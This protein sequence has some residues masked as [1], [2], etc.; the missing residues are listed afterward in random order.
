MR[1]GDLGLWSECGGRR[2]A[3]LW[4]ENTLNER[5]S[6]WLSI[7]TLLDVFGARSGRGIEAEKEAEGK[8]GSIRVVGHLVEDEEER[9]SHGLSIESWLELFESW[10]GR[11][12][13]GE[14]APF[15]S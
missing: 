8:G 11:G 15:V 12:S 6:R 5:A 9:P 3:I 13:E 2:R 7:D 10:K 14:A 1:G 4:K